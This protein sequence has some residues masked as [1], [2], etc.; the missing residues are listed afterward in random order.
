L[1]TF[2]IYITGGVPDITFPPQNQ[3]V[4]IFTGNESVTFT[5]LAEGEGLLYSWERQGSR[6]PLS[7]TTHT[8]VISGVREENSGN[9]RCIVENRFGQVTSDYASLN[10]TGRKLHSCVCLC[11]Q[12]NA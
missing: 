8:L 11:M 6:S 2:I 5:C 3:T 4:G 12:P 10:V 7:T 9:Y 1:L